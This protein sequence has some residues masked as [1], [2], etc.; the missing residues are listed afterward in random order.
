M[1]EVMTEE[2]KGY[3]IKI[4]IDENPFSPREDDNL[5]TMVCFHRRY[6]LGDK[7]DF[8]T[9]DDCVQFSKKKDVISLPLYLYDHSGITMKTTPFTCPWDSG[10]VGFIYVGKEKIREWYQIKKVTKKVIERVLKALE[11]EV[12]TYDRYLRGEVFGFQIEKNDE[13]VDS[14]WGFIGEQEEV[15]QRAKEEVDCYSKEDLPVQEKV[16]S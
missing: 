8:E 6:D 3:K 10:Q 2:Y 9:P 15:I 4:C 13:I 1:Q 16:K 11:S 12:E 7:H 14:C 5:G